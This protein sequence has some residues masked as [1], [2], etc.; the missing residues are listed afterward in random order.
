MC[1]KVLVTVHSRNVVT[2]EI[3]MRTCKIHFNEK[4]TTST[5]YQ[6]LAFVTKNHHK[7]QYSSSTS[8]VLNL[9]YLRASLCIVTL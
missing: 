2:D 6:N 1:E 7:S 8:F 3:L 4:K 9:G 5:R